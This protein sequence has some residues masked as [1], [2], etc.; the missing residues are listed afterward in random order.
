LDDQIY[1]NRDK[2]SEYIGRKFK[3]ENQPNDPAMLNKVSNKVIPEF[4]VKKPE[5]QT[6]SIVHLPFAE[7][8]ARF[9]KPE[10]PSQDS[11]FKHKE[12]SS[13]SNS[14]AD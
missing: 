1:S 7:I 2:F 13:F 3:H 6:L 14:N 10:A 12:E 5:G 11:S 9:E 4:F 8:I